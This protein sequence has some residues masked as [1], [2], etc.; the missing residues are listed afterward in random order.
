MLKVGVPNDALN[1]TILD[2]QDDSEED[3]AEIEKRKKAE[4]EFFKDYYGS[5][6]DDEDDDYYDRTSSKDT[7]KGGKGAKSQQKQQAD[8]YDTLLAKKNVLDQIKRS[9]LAEVA[10]LEQQSKEQQ[11][12]T[13]KL[14]SSNILKVSE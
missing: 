9:L 3:D 2:F 1:V 4:A 6:D 7:K 14:R 10:Y 12:S 13:S 11:K 5:D 8:N